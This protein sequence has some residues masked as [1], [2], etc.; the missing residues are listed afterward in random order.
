MS[1]D[2]YWEFCLTFSSWLS[3]N[4]YYGKNVEQRRNYTM[5]DPYAWI[6]TALDALK[7][8]Y[9]INSMMII[10]TLFPITMWL[11][12]WS[13]SVVMFNEGGKLCKR[14]SVIYSVTDDLSFR[15]RTSNDCLLPDFLFR[16]LLVWIFFLEFLIDWYMTCFTSI[17]LYLLDN[18]QTIYTQTCATI[19]SIS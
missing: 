2:A 13:P 18:C 4:L 19:I 12:D 6:L 14:Y 17:W 10:D 9:K 7:S 16:A 5:K 15:K 8:S 11:I 3:R 1:T